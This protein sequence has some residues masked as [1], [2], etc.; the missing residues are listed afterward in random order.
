M[1]KHAYTNDNLSEH[2]K[3]LLQHSREAYEALQSSN[4][5]DKQINKRISSTQIPEDWVKLTNKDSSCDHLNKKIA[6]Q[7]AILTRWKKKRVSKVVSSRC[8]LKRKVPA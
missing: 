7:K 5:L 6:H 4:G 3:E 8:M 1:T 2:E